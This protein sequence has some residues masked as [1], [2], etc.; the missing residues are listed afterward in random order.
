MLADRGQQ[1]AAQH[2]Q[3]LYLADANNSTAMY[4]KVEVWAFL[5]NFKAEDIASV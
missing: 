3:R 5:Q 1:L 4:T 2:R